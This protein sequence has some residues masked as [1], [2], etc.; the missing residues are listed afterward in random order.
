MLKQRALVYR[1]DP[2]SG[3]PVPLSFVDFET[4]TVLL[5]AGLKGPAKGSRGNIFLPDN[6]LKNIASDGRPAFVK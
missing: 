5:P 6:G 3:N 1:D 2:K 4:G